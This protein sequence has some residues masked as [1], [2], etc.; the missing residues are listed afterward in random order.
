MWQRTA[1]ILDSLAVLDSP[2]SS[3]LHPLAT[4]RPPVG[5]V[6]V[7]SHT[8]RRDVRHRTRLVQGRSPPRS[9]IMHALYLRPAPSSSFL[10]PRF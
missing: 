10:L 2:D 1:D 3:E 9:A 6:V 7:P 5:D 8:A 4:Q